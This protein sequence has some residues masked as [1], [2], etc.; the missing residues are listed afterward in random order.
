MA[1]MN[2]LSLYLFFTLLFFIC[3]ILNFFSF[4]LINSNNTQQISN[5]Q[6]NNKS[7]NWTW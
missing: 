1:P 5:K 7:N 6:I 3:I 2:W 4:S